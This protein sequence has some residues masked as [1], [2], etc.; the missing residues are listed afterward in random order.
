MYIWR[1]WREREGERR[2]ETYFSPVI[3]APNC[4]PVDRHV[5]PS[6]SPH[7]SYMMLSLD[8]SIKG[9]H[10]SFIIFFSFKNLLSLL[11]F[12]LSLLFSRSD[13]LFE[14]KWKNF[15]SANRYAYGVF[16]LCV[17]VCTCLMKLK[18]CWDLVLSSQSASLPLF[19]HNV[20]VCVLCVWVRERENENYEWTIP[21]TRQ[22]LHFEAFFFFGVLYWQT[23]TSLSPLRQLSCEFFALSKI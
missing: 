13:R 3:Q 14:F 4:A 16:I 11:E 15:T 1:F 19:S 8:W 20:L 10:S 9:K 7:L 2:I 6:H 18:C 5:C 21:L 23:S 12:A 17:C 22:I